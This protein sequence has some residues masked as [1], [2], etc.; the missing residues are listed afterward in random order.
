[1][2]STGKKGGDANI[3]SAGA[4]ASNKVNFGVHRAVN[5][6]GNKVLV[7]HGAYADEFR[8]DLI[9]AAGRNTAWQNQIGGGAL[10]RWDGAKKALLSIF[11]DS[12]FLTKKTTFE[13]KV[14]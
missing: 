11:T 6:I 14:K 5:T 9:T 12:N 3:A 4:L 2:S 1:M 13:S 7:S 8:G 10:T